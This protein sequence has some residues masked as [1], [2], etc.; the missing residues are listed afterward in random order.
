MA[1]IT[2]IIGREVLDSQGIPTVEAMVVTENGVGGIV[3]CCND[4]A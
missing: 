2:N 4:V 1:Q 3:V